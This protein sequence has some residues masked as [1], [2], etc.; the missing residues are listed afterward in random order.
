MEFGSQGKRTDTSEEQQEL[1]YGMLS[2][3]SRE[4]L[5]K[6]LYEER[7]VNKSLCNDLAQKTKQELESGTKHRKKCNRLFES[8]IEESENK[9]KRMQDHIKVRPIELTFRSKTLSLTYWRMN[10]N[11]TVLYATYINGNKLQENIGRIV[12]THL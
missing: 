3:L 12:K 10:Y 6:L 9:I 1:D 4:T 11:A 8:L 2:H 5:K 7:K